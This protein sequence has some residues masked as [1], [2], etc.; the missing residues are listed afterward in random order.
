MEGSCEL[1]GEYGSPGACSALCNSV[2]MILT[3][4]L[5]NKIAFLAAFAF[6]MSRIQ[7]ALLR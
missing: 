3:N 2:L 7:A 6:E 5:L 1:V 4:D